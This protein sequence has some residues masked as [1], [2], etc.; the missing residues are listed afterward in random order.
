MGLISEFKAFAMRGNVMD[1][2]VG[3]VMGA[4]FQKIVS[5]LVEKIIMPITGA[6]TGGVNF[7]DRSSK[8]EVP[9]LDPAN[10]PEVGW[11]AFV[12]STID[13]LIVAL[14][15]FFVIKLMNSVQKKEEPAPEKT[16]EDI[17]LLREIRDSLKKS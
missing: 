9:G 4:S 12:Q 3:L 11:G 8:I 17:E 7:A 13:F 16:P 10:A 15:I 1:M 2:A 14:A 6:L 5:T